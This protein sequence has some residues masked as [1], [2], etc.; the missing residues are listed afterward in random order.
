MPVF[1]VF[2]DNLNAEMSRRGHV[3]NDIVDRFSCLVNVP[4]TS[5]TKEGVQYSECCEELINAYPEDLSSNFLLSFISFNH[6]FAISFVRQNQEIPD[7]VMQNC[8]RL[9]LVTR[10]D[11]ILC[12]NND[13]S[14]ITKINNVMPKIVW[15]DHTVLIA[16]IDIKW[17]RFSAKIA[18]MTDWSQLGNADCRSQFVANFQ[19]SCDEGQALVNAVR[20]D[21]IALPVMKRRHLISGM[22][23]ILNYA[24]RQV[25]SSTDNYGDSSRQ[26]ADA[27][28][29]QDALHA[30][31]ATKAASEIIDEIGLHMVQCKPADA[32]RAINRLT[33]R[34][35]R[36]FICLSAASIAD[37]K[38]HLTNHY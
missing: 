28:T 3:Y 4:E 7:S 31:A 1:Y 29:N 10:L 23:T 13:K 36:P 30:S 27:I 22:I 37:R 26:Y 19:K 16:N 12:K 24:R 21:S 35:C 17:K 33:C 18:P 20:Y 2:I 6:I 25:Q 11:W 15:S 5:S 38:L 14:H 9:L 8:I 32:W 34:K